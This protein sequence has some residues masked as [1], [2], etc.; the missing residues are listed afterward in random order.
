MLA[1]YS[2]V[3]A[4]LEYDVVKTFLIIGLKRLSGGKS[5]AH[6]PPQAVCV[7]GSSKRFA[8]TERFTL[9]HSGLF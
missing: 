8:I 1:L 7:I 3:S 6:K 9:S 5:V 2:F 4:E